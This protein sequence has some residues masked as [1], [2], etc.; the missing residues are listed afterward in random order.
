MTA[1]IHCCEISILK[2]NLATSIWGAFRFRTTTLKFCL[3]KDQLFPPSIQIAVCSIY[4]LAR[5]DGH[6]SLL[7]NIDIEIQSGNIHLGRVSI[8]DNDVEILL[9]ERPT[10]SA[11]HPNRSLLD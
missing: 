1:I 10:L 3:T 2:S 8:S 4:R 6:H 7:R 11:V 9:D 5:N